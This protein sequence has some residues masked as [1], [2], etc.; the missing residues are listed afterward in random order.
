MAGY[1]Q[2]VNMNKEYIDVKFSK[3]FESCQNKNTK[4]NMYCI[5]L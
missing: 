1:D 4:G 2:M 3:K 5:C